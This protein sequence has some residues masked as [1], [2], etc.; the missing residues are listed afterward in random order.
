MADKPD[1]RN[2][3]QSAEPV[4]GSLQK[5]SYGSGRTDAAGKATDPAK[6]QQEFAE[7]TQRMQQQFTPEKQNAIRQLDDQAAQISA[8]LP[9]EEQTAMVSK[10]QEFASADNADQRQQAVKDIVGCISDPTLKQQ[11]TDVLNQEDKII[12]PELWETLHKY[13]KVGT[14]ISAMN[15]P[16]MGQQG[17]SNPYSDPNK[18]LF[19]LEQDYDSHIDRLLKASD[20]QMIKVA[21]HAVLEGNLPALENI[22]KGN[23]KKIAAIANDVNQGLQSVNSPLSLASTPG[24]VFLQSAGA[25]RVIDIDTK[26]HSAVEHPAQP[27]PDG[28]MSIDTASIIT[29]DATKDARS[30]AQQS[31][32]GGSYGGRNS[33]SA[34]GSNQSYYD[35]GASRN[36]Y[37]GRSSNSPDGQRQYRSDQYRS[38]SQQAYQAQQ[39]ALVDNPGGVPPTVTQKLAQ[40]ENSFQAATD[41]KDALKAEDSAFQTLLKEADENFQKKYAEK[42]SLDKQLKA[43]L[44]PEKQQQLMD[45]MMKAAED[46]SKLPPDQQQQAMAALSGFG[47]GGEFLLQHP[48]LADSLRESASLMKAYEPILQKSQEIQHA[49]DEKM[50]VGLN[51]ARDLAKAGDPRAKDVF[52]QTFDSLP[53][54]MKKSYVLNPDIRA[55]AK[56]LGITLPGAPKEKAVSGD[57][58]LLI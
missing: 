4:Y 10:Y 57:A 7:L 55:V 44:P 43:A 36:Y 21:G 46:F 37:K 35:Q 32:Y 56:S 8:K 52:T 53:D 31:L 45:A 2:A 47:D 49:A 11:M 19:N 15:P 26:K 29:G 24:H 51:Y 6:L 41:P 5:D 9:K 39:Q 25:S 42:E 58:R 12:G 1:P 27:Q 13:N 50:E 17:D 16:N 30:M 28:T 23:D 3:Q 33:W 14:E 48:V 54:E 38:D 22:F 34:T 18:T 40:L 20:R